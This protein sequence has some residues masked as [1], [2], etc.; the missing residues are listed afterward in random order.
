VKT[1]VEPAE[2]SSTS[3]AAAAKGAKEGHRVTRLN[4]DLVPQAFSHFTIV[5]SERPTSYFVGP[6]GKMGRCCVCDLQ[7]CFDK[8]ANTFLLSEYVAAI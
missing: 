8:E 2:L 6:S 7:G 1:E 5:H 3:A 4:S